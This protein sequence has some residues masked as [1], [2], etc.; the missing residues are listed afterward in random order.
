[1]GISLARPSPP[2]PLTDQWALTCS[3]H[4][5][6]LRLGAAQ[7]SPLQAERAVVEYGAAVAMERAAT[8]WHQ[9]EQYEAQVW[10]RAAEHALSAAL[11][12]VPW[13]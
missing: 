2:P 7:A 3:V 12:P 4:A 1:M 9:D 13:L 11:I 6:A 10:M 8:H 5:Q